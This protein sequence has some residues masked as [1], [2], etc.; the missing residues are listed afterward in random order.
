MAIPVPVG[1]Y[2]GAD[3]PA[4]WTVVRMSDVRCDER[5]GGLLKHYHRRAA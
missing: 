5:L 4:P 2:P 3:L 1:G